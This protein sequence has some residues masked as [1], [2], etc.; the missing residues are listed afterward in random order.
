MA[1]CNDYTL[2]SKSLAG[3]ILLP[4][5]TDGLC[6]V[7]R[8]RQTDQTGFITIPALAHILPAKC[9]PFMVYFNIKIHLTGIFHADSL[10][11][12]F[13]E[14]TNSCLKIRCPQ[15]L[16]AIL[17]LGKEFLD[18]ILNEWQDTD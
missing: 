11:I 12:P 15:I 16:Q 10:F 1:F 18:S 6:Y 14:C 4:A 7:F 17:S 2:A 9:L 8:N 3:N 13:E 5:R